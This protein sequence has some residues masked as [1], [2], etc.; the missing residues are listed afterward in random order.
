[1]PLSTGT[2]MYTS[3]PAFVFPTTRALLNFRGTSVLYA[4]RR[5]LGAHLASGAATHLGVAVAVS[6]ASGTWFHFSEPR[7][8]RS[9]AISASGAG[10][11]SARAG[12]G[13]STASAA[14]ARRDAAK[15]NGRGM[16][17]VREGA[18]EARVP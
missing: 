17:E 18:R 14:V 3:V 13:A 15:R 4:V 6:R 10:G 7:A 16:V 5:D 11:A 12:D 8:S 1:M 9:F 2:C